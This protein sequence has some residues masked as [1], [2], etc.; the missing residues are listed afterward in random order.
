ME[1]GDF[2]CSKKGIADVEFYS[3][4]K[5][6]TDVK[7]LCRLSAAL[8]EPWII[9]QD[10]FRRKKLFAE[11]RSFF[12]KPPENSLTNYEIL[13]Q[14]DQNKRQQEFRYFRCC[15]ICYNEAYM[16]PTLWFNFYSLEGRLLLLEE[17]EPLIGELF[18]PGESILGKTTSKESGARRPLFLMEAISQAEHPHLGIAF[19]Q[20]HPCRTGDLL[21]PLSPRNHVLSFLSLMNPILGFRLVPLEL[22]SQVPPKENEKE[23]I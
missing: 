10:P 8:S 11:Q 7:E 19:Y 21:R 3:E 18:P 2:D 17:L 1:S 16:V 22:F 15:T 6:Q 9:R 5:F 13:K 23:T 4:S 14:L 12:P 20:F